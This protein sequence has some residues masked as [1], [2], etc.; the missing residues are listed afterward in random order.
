MVLDAGPADVGHATVDH[1]HLAVVEVEGVLGVEPDAPVADT[2]AADDRDA[3][4]RDDLDAG[5]PH[6]L[7]QSAAVESTPLPIASTATLTS[8]PARARS[9][10][11]STTASAIVPGR[12]A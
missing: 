5:R 1:H 9:S 10:S 4:V 8:R 6:P 12:I 7:V 2:A 11:A 3:V